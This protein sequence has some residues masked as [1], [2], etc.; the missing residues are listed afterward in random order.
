MTEFIKKV[1]V[2]NQVAPGGG[3]GSVVDQGAPNADCNQG[4]P[5][6]LTGIDGDA[7]IACV[8]VA[9]VATSSVRV[10]IV[11]GLPQQTDIV[12]FSGTI[13]VGGTSQLAIPFNLNRRYL[14]IQNVDA[15]DLWINF[16]LAAT[17]GQPSIK[18]APGEK[19]IMDSSI[20]AITDMYVIG[21]LTGQQYTAKSS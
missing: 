11:A 18:L 2:V 4:W 21:A 10:N 14:L 15:G 1:L 6:R 12:D 20:V 7:G 9:D 5:V 3:G 17:I 16:N 19:F 13:A 8:D